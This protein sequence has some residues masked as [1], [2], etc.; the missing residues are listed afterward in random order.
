MQT[1]ARCQKWK[2]LAGQCTVCASLERLR[3]AVSSNRLPTTLKAE[4]KTTILDGAYRLFPESDE[5]SEKGGSPPKKSTEG[6]T[7]KG[8][9]PPKPASG[10]KE[11]KAHSPREEVSEKKFKPIETSRREGSKIS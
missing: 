3:A 7:S 5:E 8:G 1:C 11:K 2:L 4:A 10:E 9:E 6:S